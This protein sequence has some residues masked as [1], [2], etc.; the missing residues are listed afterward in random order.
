MTNMA[1]LQW[2][3][4]LSMWGFRDE[5]RRGLS[6]DSLADGIMMNYDE[7]VGRVS[8]QGPKRQSK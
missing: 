6:L 3:M 5:G 1:L 7:F 4:A 8:P 2:S